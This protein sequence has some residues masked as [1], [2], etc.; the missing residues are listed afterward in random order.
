ML[1]R[2]ITL[3]E[4]I[5]EQKF[6]ETEALLSL[7]TQLAAVKFRSWLVSEESSDE[8]SLAPVQ[9]LIVRRNVGWSFHRFYT[10]E[11]V[12][13]KQ[14]FS[15][16]ERTDYS[17]SAISEA[18]QQIFSQ[19][20]FSLHQRQL[21]AVI[22]ACQNRTTIISGGPGTGKTTVCAQIIRTI[23]NLNPELESSDVALAAP[24]GR[25][26]ARLKESVQNQLQDMSKF[27][28]LRSSTLHILLRFSRRSNDFTYNADNKLP[29]KLVIID[30]SS[31]IDLSMFAKF[32]D[33]LDPEC[34][35][36]LLGDKNQLP[37][38]NAGAV[39][40]DLSGAFYGNATL[41][42]LSA[43]RDKQ[44][45]K[46][47]GKVPHSAENHKSMRFRGTNN[48]LVD[49]IMLLTHSFRYNQSIGEL[50][51]AVQEGNVDK[52]EDILQKGGELSQAPEDLA[53]TLQQWMELR[54]KNEYLR[55]CQQDF[56]NHQLNDELPQ[57]H[58]AAQ[59]VIAHLNRSRILCPIKGSVQGVH[60]INQH[61]QHS[62]LRSHEFVAGT[63]LLIQRNS[64]KLDLFNGD[65][66]VV[67]KCAEG[68]G[69]L[70][71]MG[72]KFRIISLANLPKHELCHA[73]TVHKA[74]GSEYDNVLLVLPSQDSILLSREIIYTGV[75]RTKESLQIYG[76]QRELGSR[77]LHRTLTRDSG[78]LDDN[79][80][81]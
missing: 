41:A 58:A 38:V 21:A 20:E 43:E 54:Y 62:W 1:Q 49:N 40:G 45:Q 35:L 67:V 73:M 28:D 11:E 51:Q 39:L 63:P 52:F 17:D 47:M 65:T 10:A 74:Q 59:A 3:A 57:D 60:A 2:H 80:E 81:G 78:I 71:E 69:F 27:H 14:F 34:Q 33:A 12:V 22:L 32:L 25:A 42:T 56:E 6:S 79:F 26:A 70:C 30:E 37:S 76:W 61:I 46:I 4:Q 77:W 9:P 50:A 19:N 66:G 18:L 7:G 75:T 72:S 23:K 31:M 29:Y 68:L 48:P 53:T 24:T 5:L 36:V 16:L 8:E 44:L 13:K 64:Y 15:R 55:S